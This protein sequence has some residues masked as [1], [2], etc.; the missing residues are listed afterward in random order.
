MNVLNGRDFNIHSKT[1]NFWNGI[2]LG[3][4]WA[5]HFQVGTRDGAIHMYR[6][7]YTWMLY[8]FML[9]VNC[10]MYGSAKKAKV[11]NT[12]GR[13]YGIAPHIIR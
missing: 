11:P 7:R 10:S 9:T 12:K 3:R 5:V 6:K 2:L 4:G 1:I 13:N 8:G